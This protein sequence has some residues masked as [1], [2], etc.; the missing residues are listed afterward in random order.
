MDG[1]VC[2]RCGETLLADSDVRYKLKM[3][4]FAAYDPMEV[5]PSDLKR[6][7]ES[8]LSSL[9]TE[10]EK[11]DPQKL[12]DQVYKRFDFDICPECQEQILRNPLG[13]N[14][15]RDAP[16][17]D[18]SCDDT[19]EDSVERDREGDGEKDFPSGKD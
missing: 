5:S 19:G 10:M 15:G 8:E 13:L 18:E 17:V 11:M 14:I 1:L 6:D 4:I 7:L 16:D 9:I 12:E 3:E 2:D